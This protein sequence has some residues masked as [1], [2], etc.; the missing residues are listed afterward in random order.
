[1]VMVHGDDQGLVLPPSVAA[2]Q[3]VI[4]PAGLKKNTPDEM[5]AKVKQG[6]M[7]IYMTL[8]QAGLRVKLDDTDDLTFGYKCNEWE[9]RGVPMRIELGP[10]DLANGTFEMAKRNVLGKS[11]KVKG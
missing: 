10:N 5:K 11:G 4:V 3:V 7:D 2:L 1:M 8:C 6:C 9:M